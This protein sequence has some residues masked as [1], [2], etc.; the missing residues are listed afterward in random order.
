MPPLRIAMLAPLVAPMREPESCGNHR[1]IAD[2][3]RGFAARGHDVTLFAAAGSDV[4]G[5]RVI[6]I[7]VAPEGRRAFALLGP[8]GSA[9]RHAL[10]QAFARAVAEVRRYG[11]DVISQHAFD[12]PAIDGTASWPTVHTLHLPPI[13]PDVVRALRRTSGRIVAVSAS[14]GERWRGILGREIA[15]IP[16]GVPGAAPSPRATGGYALIAGRISAEKGTAVA[17]RA[18][19]DLGLRAR[20]AGEIYD[21]SYFEREVAPLLGE[22]ELVGTLARDQ[23]WQ[24]M[25]AADVVLM[26]ITWD[27]PFGLVAAEAQLAGCPVAGFRRGALTE[28]V[29]DGIGGYL[30]APGDLPALVRAARACR[31]LDRAAIRAAAR[32]RFAIEPC[33]AAHERVLIEQAEAGASCASL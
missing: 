22:G 11:C 25:A 6:G 16:N 19:R 7:D 1:I 4:A 18:A 15:V 33:I 2:L 24:L 17:L 32:T 14:A 5:I 20:V 29:L 3:A 31:S 23:L 28:V 10:E 27:E 13:V 21:R 8:G 9:A 30:A 12:A 26:P